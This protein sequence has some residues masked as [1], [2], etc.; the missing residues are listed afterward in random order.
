MGKAGATHPVLQEPSREFAWEQEAARS[1][2]QR[3]MVGTMLHWRACGLLQPS[4]LAAL[5][6]RKVLLGGNA[7]SEVIFPQKPQI[8]VFK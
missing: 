8:W 1:V 5:S 2:R 6:C 7:G 3:A 4:T